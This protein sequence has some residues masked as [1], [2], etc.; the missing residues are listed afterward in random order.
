MDLSMHIIKQFLDHEED[1][2]E[3]NFLFS[4]L[5]I[6]ILLS[7]VAFG[8][9]P[10]PTLDP[11]LYLLGSKSVADLNAQATDRNLQLALFGSSK[12]DEGSF[13]TKKSKRK[14]LLD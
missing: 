5:S 3:K 6:S 4:P 8:L 9:N 11:L 2:L 7:M 12:K 14:R 1:K 13:Q 10:G